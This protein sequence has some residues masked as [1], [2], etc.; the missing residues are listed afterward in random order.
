[1]D[2]PEP[3]ASTSKL[4]DVS[5]LADLLTSGPADKT[6]ASS[7]NQP[8]SK[9]YLSQL[10][11]F[12]ISDLFAEPTTLQTQA[13]HLTSS[14]T[15]LTHTSYPTFLSL[16]RTTSALTNSLE[17]L[18][19]SLDSLLNKSLPALEESATNWKQRT[20]EVLRERGRA[21]V[22]L[23][24]HDKIRDL[25]DIPLLIDACV[26]NGYFA[27]A[28]SL[29][30]HAKALSSSPSFQDKT[31]PLVLQSVL[32]EVHN[33]ITQM[34]LS[35]LA[36]LYEP[37][38]KLPALWKAVNFL[39]KMDAFGPS[40]PFASLEGKSKTRVYLSSE[41]IVNPEDEIT[42]EE[43]IA[44]A[45]LVGR[46]TCLKSSLE[47]VGNDVSRL[48]KNEDL[49]DRE[50]DDLARYL[51]KYIDVWREGAYDVITQYTTIFLEK[52]ST[53][54]PASN[55]TPVSASSSANQGQELLRLHS[56]ITTFASHTLNTHLIPILAPALPLL[57]LSLLPSL[58]T[59]L[60]Y[61]ST[62]FARVGLDFRGILS[63]LFADAIL[64]VVGRD[65]RAASDQWLSRLRK[66]SGA[67]ST[68]TRDRKQVSPPSKWL[69]A[70][71]AVSSPPLP[72]PNAVQ[73]PPHIPPQI[74]ASYPPLAEHT[75]SLLGV[76][77]ALRLLAPLS[78]VSDLVE[79]VDDVLAEG[80]NALLTYL[81]A[82]TI[83][84]AQ[85]TAVTDDELD[86]RKRDKRVALAIG[87]VY[88][89]VFLPF[90]R[91]ALVQGVYS[92]QVEVKSETNETKLKEVQT[93]WD[94]LKMELEQSGP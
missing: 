90:I 55:R 72:A 59:Q 9:D 29:S 27:E 61:C 57:S 6:A 39:R 43:Q 23:D 12:S 40:S 65:V 67:N 21:R 20:E 17:S 92:S 48:S 11:T 2:P 51:K 33:S 77:N 47:T 31:P 36:T 85:S 80:A 91:R 83:N 3:V 34:L 56:L 13:H 49:D 60:T 4:Q 88:L 7:L 30:S 68:N 1:M 82:F 84:L 18:A 16:H 71:S 89:T 19:S 58:L 74:L 35:L 38:R 73:G 52:S 25:L 8:G 10:T 24:Q 94:K 66:A 76:F 28:L 26:R 87:E 22:V 70:T 86:R 45:F 50:K 78:I 54:V 42:N 14:L 32:S 63:L 62:A 53:S 37:N 44:L 15:S 79:V 64:Q 41:D 46:E 81:K 69:I 75:N 5:H 93:K